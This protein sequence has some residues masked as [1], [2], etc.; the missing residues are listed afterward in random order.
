MPRY[1]FHIRTPTQI[2]RDVVGE[3]LES[4]AQAREHAL[5]T[6]IEYLAKTDNP[7]LELLSVGSFEIANEYGRREMVLRFTDALPRTVR[8]A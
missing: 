2:D 4:L 8:A 6:V 3:E 7:D 5:N 1:Y